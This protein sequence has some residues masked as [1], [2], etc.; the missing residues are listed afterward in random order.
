MYR[1]KIFLKNRG[2]GG[3]GGGG[4]IDRLLLKF[5]GS[6]PQTFLAY[7]LKLGFFIFFTSA[8]FVQSCAQHRVHK[9]FSVLRPTAC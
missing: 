3:G 2:A 1:K 8:R 4:R 5:C 7:F 6:K 9:A